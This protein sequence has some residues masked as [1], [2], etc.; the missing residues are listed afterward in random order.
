M[1]KTVI[2]LIVVLFLSLS[3]GVIA[4]AEES[5]ADYYG[6]YTLKGES[7]VQGIILEEN[8]FEMVLNLSKDTSNDK[9]HETILSVAIQM[10]SNAQ[11]VGKI[12]TQAD[13]SKESAPE[14]IWQ[15][16]FANKPLGNY[17]LVA[18]SSRAPHYELVDGTLFISVDGTQLFKLKLAENNHLVDAFNH[19]FERVSE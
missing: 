6:T 16:S 17:P 13:T 10:T 15:M 18:L 2:Q 12:D 7:Q 9:Y 5:V 19:S 14:A 1:R 8:Y 3:V 11:R 4:H